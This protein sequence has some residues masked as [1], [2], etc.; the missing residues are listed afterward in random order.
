MSITHATRAVIGDAGV[1]AEAEHADQIR[2]E[3]LLAAVLADVSIQDALARADQPVDVGLVLAD[4]RRARRR[5]GLTAAESDALSGLGIDVDQLVERVEATLGEGA[6][7]GSRPTRPAWRGLSV[8]AGLNQV[9]AAG[10]RQM[11][12]RGERRLDVAH[13]LLGL[14]DH[15]GLVA[16]ALARQ[17]VTLAAV[18][19]AL[20]VRR[21]DQDGSR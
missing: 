4:V 12:A 17:G 20:A 15:P 3:H 9:L 7:D 5:A 18:Q 8:S 16:D 21:V 10:H 6:L 14:L 2:E 13:I 11:L 1:R 19:P